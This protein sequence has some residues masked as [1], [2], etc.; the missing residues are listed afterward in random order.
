M[1]GKRTVATDV[2]DEDFPLEQLEE[3][4]KRTTRHQSESERRTIRQESYAA[5]GAL[6][7]MSMTKINFQERPSIACANDF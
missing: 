2:E 6:L 4:V 5:I 1:A 3:I 7:G